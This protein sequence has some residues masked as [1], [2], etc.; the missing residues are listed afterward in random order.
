MFSVLGFGNWR[1]AAT[2]IPVLAVLTLFVSWP[3]FAYR[4]WFMVLAAAGVT[5][6]AAFL[7]EARRLITAGKNHGEAFLF[8]WVPMVLLFFVLTAEM[9]NARYLLLLMAPLCL[10][11]FSDASEGRLILVL[12]PTIAFSVAL[13][14]ADFKFVNLNRDLVEQAVVPLQRQGFRVWSAAESGLRFYLEQQGI[15]TLATDDVSP[16]PS[17]LI[18]RHKGPFSY[19]LAEQIATRLT[20]L[21]TFALNNPFPLRVYSL[22]AGAGFHDSGAG[23]VPFTFSRVPYDPVEVV[24]MSPLGL[25]AVWSPDGPIFIQKEPEREFTVNI[26]SDTKS[27]YEL[28]GDGVAALYADRIV[29][30]KGDSPATVW[31]NF[32]VVPKHWRSP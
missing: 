17:D 30:R 7:T 5:I 28:D 15:V 11:L 25:A 23:L 13:A 14:Y 20:V 24:Q 1:V 22:P 2:S 10:V 8:L 6:L 26:P 9:I 18:V 16:G 12:I 32:R 31:K 19:S 4:A 29:L 3:S 27:E 21:K